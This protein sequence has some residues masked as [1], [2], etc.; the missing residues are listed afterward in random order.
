MPNLYVN[1]EEYNFL[2]NLIEEAML[3]CGE[4]DADSYDYADSLLQK[5][6]Y[7]PSYIHEIH[8]RLANG[9]FRYD[10][11]CKVKSHSDLKK[12]VDF[13]DEEVHALKDIVCFAFSLKYEPHSVLENADNAY[14]KVKR[15]VKF[16][17]EK[18]YDDPGV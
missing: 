1:Q 7:P 4:I 13:T 16:R 10:I 17:K 9:D 14:H 11:R 8:T 15:I 12:L 5:L 3:T 18:H 6:N 2:I